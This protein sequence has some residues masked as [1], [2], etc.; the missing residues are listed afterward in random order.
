VDRLLLFFFSGEGREATGAFRKA[1]VDE[2]IGR[3]SSS[4]LHSATLSVSRLGEVSTPLWRRFCS[5]SV[6]FIFFLLNL[7]MFLLSFL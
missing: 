3:F 1:F 2:G 5:R 4:P 7:H 6:T